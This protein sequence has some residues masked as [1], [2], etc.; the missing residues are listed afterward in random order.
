MGLIE[1]QIRFYNHSSCYIHIHLN[2][3]F[4]PVDR[5]MMVVEYDQY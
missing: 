1:Q 2:N 4:Y 3:Y 5:Q